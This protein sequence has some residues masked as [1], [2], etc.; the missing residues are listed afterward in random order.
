MRCGGHGIFG[1]VAFSASASEFS[2][3][4]EFYKDQHR[5]AA[6]AHFNVGRDDR[7]ARGESLGT[8]LGIIDVI[9]LR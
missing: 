8:P 4:A 2:G 6:A 5:R 1:T 9:C 3:A 7:N